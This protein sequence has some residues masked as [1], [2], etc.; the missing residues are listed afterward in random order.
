[1]VV[2]HEPEK[3]QDQ[4]LQGCS[5]PAVAVRGWMAGVKQWFPEEE[6]PLTN[7]CQD[8]HCHIFHLVCPIRVLPRSNSVSWFAAQAGQL[9]MF[10]AGYPKREPFP[11]LLT[12][13]VSP[14]KAPASPS[15]C[16]QWDWQHTWAFQHFLQDLVISV[17]QVAIQKC[18]W[19]GF[20]CWRKP[21][22]RNSC[23]KPLCNTKSCG[24]TPYRLPL[25]QHIQEQYQMM[26]CHV[27]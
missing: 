17:K 2:Q 26:I 6:L 23:A 20:V 5:P 25:S 8:P 18:I 13:P 7:L 3:P 9:V 11:I 24:F 22:L 21:G 16:M 19:K 14:S 12:K 27:I 4:V 10:C 15:R 1:M